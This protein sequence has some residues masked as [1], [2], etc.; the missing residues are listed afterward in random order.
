MQIGIVGLPSCGKTT[1]FQT[2]TRTHLD[3]A[4]LHHKEA[5]SAV[6]K[7]PDERLAKLTEIFK[8]KR[9]VRAAI[10]FVDV[11]GLKKGD[12]SSTQFTG[13]FLAGVK[14]NDAL[15][16]VV[17]MFDNPLYPHPEGSIDPLRDIRLLDTEFILAD[18][19]ML[20]HRIDRVKKTALKSGDALSKAEL[21]VL[22]RCLRALEQ[23]QPIRALELNDPERKMLKGYAF[24][25]AKPQLV[26]INME[27]KEIIRKDEIV[28]EISSKYAGKGIRI[29]ALFGQIEMEMA[30]LAD[31]EAA[32]FMQEYGI[33]ESALD[34][35]IR[36]AYALLG[37]QS[38]FTAGEDETR[39]WTIARGMNAQEAAGAIHTDF[40]DKFIRAEVVHY[41]DF[42][43]HGSFAK[44]KEVGAWRLEGKEYV[45]K[46]GDILVIRHG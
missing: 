33:A 29:D 24:L 35:I 30:Q 11:V 36:D 38:F 2:M 6:V 28:K 44:C 31:D 21:P 46:D 22:E 9:E 7:V 8:P 10:E 40:F 3:A 42:I 18:M 15:L 27:D 1:L 12:H 34:R 23:E 41:E 32:A 14:T 43:R 19:A 37:L 39:A 16:Q 5:N 4:A 45:V 13:N 17:R 20:E 25:T 26:L